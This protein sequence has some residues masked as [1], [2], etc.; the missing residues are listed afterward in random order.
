MNKNIFKGNTASVPKADAVN[1]AGGIAYSM[2][3]KHALAQMAA[4]GCINGTYYAT[5]DKQA[6][7]IL[8]WAATCSPDFVGKTAI[9]ARE[10]GFMK[11]TPALLC[12]HLAAR[13]VTVLKRVFDRVIDNPKMLRNFAQAIR[14]GVVGRKSFGTAPKKLM[15]RWIEGRTDEQLFRGSIGNDPSLADVIKMV[16]PKPTSPT[17]S[18]LYAYLIGKEPAQ[19]DSQAAA[20]E[21]VESNPGAKVWQ[22][23]LGFKGDNTITGGQKTL[24][25]GVPEALLPPIIVE[26]ERFKAEGG[27]VPDVPFEMLTALNIGTK[28]WMAIAER[29][30]WTQTRMNLNTF[31]RHGVFKDKGYVAM[32]AQKLA[33]GDAIKRA[34]AFPYQ[35]MAAYTNASDS[36]PMEIRIALQD[37]ME[38]A[39]DNV[40]TYEGKV[41]VFPD[42]SGSMSSAITGNRLGATSKMRCIDVAALVAASVLRKNPNAEVIPFET[43]VHALRLNPRDSIMTN[44]EKLARIGGGGTNCSAP[45]A[46]LNRVKAQGDLCIY[47]SDN[48]SWADGMGNPTR[49]YRGGTGSQT[50]WQKFQARNPRAKLVCIDIQPNDTTQAKD[51]PSILNVGGFSD[52]VFEVINQFAAGGNA[53]HHWVEVIEGIKI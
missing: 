51:S 2:G 36:M 34:R 40:P 9:Y 19:K 22:V 39:V 33:D 24:G 29:A 23:P 46:M 7:D 14:S 12:A 27:E 49:Y 16:R 43:T 1:E 32:V 21:L 6:A 42:V 38:L 48:E 35:L 45:L 4:T 25:I 44:A 47:V 15:Q 28:E 31:E 53:A 13:D 17:R 26:Y 20:A 3:S 18:A 41:Y 52:S 50:E 30:T 11:D 37:A 8:A 5:A 10:K